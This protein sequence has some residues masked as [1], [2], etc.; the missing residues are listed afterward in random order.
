MITM[1]LRP[2][3]IAGAYEL[4]AE[5]RED[6][7]GFLARTL[8]LEILRSHELLDR[9]D[10]ET[11]SYNRRRGTLRG[12]HYQAAP[13][14]QTKIVTCVAGRAFDVALDLRPDSPTFG[15]WESLELDARRCNSIYIPAGCAHGFQTF[16]PETTVF[17]RTA[18]AYR[19][20]LARG[21]DPFDADVAVR[22][23]IAEATL[24]ERDRELPA[25]HD[26]VP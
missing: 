3:T 22:W 6:E 4:I 23:P 11:F 16:E 20:E 13:A 19:E 14:W 15:R 10:Q 26:F 8:D 2:L 1:R 7:R 25:F 17:Y 12:L 24:S 9:F 18:P 5:A 21:I